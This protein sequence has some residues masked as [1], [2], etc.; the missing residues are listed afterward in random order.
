M[1]LGT[2]THSRG[3]SAK[4]R[5]PGTRTKE[6]DAIKLLTN[7]HR[8]VEKLFKEFQKAKKK[9]GSG[10]K[11][12]IAEQICKMLTIH[13]EIEEEIFY[14]Q[15]REAMADGEDIM[16]EAEVEH[17]SMK[18]IIEQLE[19]ADPD[20]EMFDAKVKVLCE[21]VNHHVKEEESKMFPKVKKSDIDLA[22]IGAK[23]MERKQE[24]MGEEEA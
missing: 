3:R 11:A 21:Y 15:A 17:A 6:P 5:S 2:Q 7:D 16:D 20:D 22:E 12:E 14:P 19:D 13:S 1:A 9:D 24:L 4:S 18:N 23:L 10:N 8:E